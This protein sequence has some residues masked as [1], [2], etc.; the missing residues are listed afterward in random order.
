MSSQPVHLALER[1]GS[2]E[3]WENNLT[4]KEQGRDY[5]PPLRKFCGGPNVLFVTIHS[6]THHRYLL[7]LVDESTD[8]Q[9]HDELC[10]PAPTS[11]SLP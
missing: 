2:K 10:Y 8:A 5:L 9:Q 6:L 4:S 7:I 11:P 3:R 1:E